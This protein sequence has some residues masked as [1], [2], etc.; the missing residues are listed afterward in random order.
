MHVL[1]SI[2]SYHWVELGLKEINFTER[3]ITTGCTPKLVIFLTAK[4]FFWHSVYSYEPS[5]CQESHRVRIH[6][7]AKPWGPHQEQGAG[8]Q[9]HRR[10]AV[11]LPSR[12]VCP[13]VDCHSDEKISPLYWSY[14]DTRRP[15]TTYTCTTSPRELPTPP[16]RS[17]AEHFTQTR[18][19]SCSVT[20]STGRGDTTSLKWGS[21]RKWWLIGRT[22]PKPGKIRN[23]S[24]N[25]YIPFL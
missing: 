5:F 12:G 6:K 19:P 18:S 13:Q 9:I 1:V 10:L 24:K 11:H 17:G 25:H 14:S 23:I 16:G 20:P 4:F 3:K 22:L 7:L 2:W 21:R 15:A 8:G